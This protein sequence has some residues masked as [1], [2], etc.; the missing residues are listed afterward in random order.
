MVEDLRV[1]MST[2]R[3]LGVRRTDEDTSHEAS[4]FVAQGGSG[5]HFD[6][7]VEE[8]QARRR[9]GQAAAGRDR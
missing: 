5:G 7:P 9:T 8:L 6:N 2:P 4:R 1:P 3:G